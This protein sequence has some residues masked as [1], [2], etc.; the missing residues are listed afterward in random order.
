MRRIKKT[1]RR[2]LM[3]GIGLL[4]LLFS[5]GTQYFSDEL[6][7]DEYI[8]PLIMM[9]DNIIRLSSNDI[10]L[11][12]HLTNPEVYDKE[13]TRNKIENKYFDN[14]FWPDIEQTRK[15]SKEQGITLT[16][17]Y[18]AF[19]LIGSLMIIYPKIFPRSRIFKKE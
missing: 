17:V 9:N 13:S 4:I 3:E 10:D 5:F 18:I 8:T 19:Y 11:I 6:K 7:K 16:Y 14:S 2:D 15:N 1:M 12:K